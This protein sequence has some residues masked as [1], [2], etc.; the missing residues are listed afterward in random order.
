MRKW[1]KKSP[2]G[3]ATK[4]EYEVGE[5]LMIPKPVAAE[6][7]MESSS[8]VSVLMKGI[9]YIMCLPK[10]PEQFGQDISRAWVGCL[11][12]QEATTITNP[13]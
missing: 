1:H 6:G 13:Q 7:L 10:C 2:I 11:H 4:W 8:N 12:G 3:G 5:D 9:A